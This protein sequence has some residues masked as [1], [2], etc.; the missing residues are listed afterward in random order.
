MRENYKEWLKKM[1]KLSHKFAPSATS[2]GAGK[3]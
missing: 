2:G 1:P 3:V